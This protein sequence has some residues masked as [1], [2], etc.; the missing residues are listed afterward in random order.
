MPVQTRASTKKCQKGCPKKPTSKRHDLYQRIVLPKTNPMWRRIDKSLHNCI[1]ISLRGVSTWK[2][3]TIEQVVNSAVSQRF[4]DAKKKL[5]RK[6]WK[7]VSSML[8]GTG[9]TNVKSICRYGLQKRYDVSAYQTRIWTSNDAGTAILYAVRRSYSTVATV[10]SCRLLHDP[11]HPDAYSL[12][13]SIIVATED[14]HI[15][16]EYLFTYHRNPG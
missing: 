10:F 6:G 11:Q 1:T 5:Q 3:K 13:N 14:E 12:G 4:N 8:H 15:H 9:R 7:E 2:L 16:P